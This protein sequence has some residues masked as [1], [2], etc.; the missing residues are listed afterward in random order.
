MGRLGRR[1]AEKYDWRIIASSVT[2]IYMQSFRVKASVG[3][4]GNSAVFSSYAHSLPREDIRHV[5]PASRGL[6]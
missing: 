1:R 2:A 6:H 3:A 4:T 5:A